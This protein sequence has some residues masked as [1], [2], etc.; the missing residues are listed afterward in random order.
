MKVGH[1]FKHGDEWFEAL[2]CPR[3]EPCGSCDAV[4]DGMLCE[5]LPDCGCEDHEVAV[6]FKRTGLPHTF[7]VPEV[8]SKWMV[9]EDGEVAEMVFKK[10]EFDR[11]GAHY[12]FEANFGTTTCENLDN[13][14]PVV[15]P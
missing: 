3:G 6:Y 15:R 12:V 5:S 1:V 7:K 8:G 2:K 4:H 10:F 14:K 9:P 13:C 11:F